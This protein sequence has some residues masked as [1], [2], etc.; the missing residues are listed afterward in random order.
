M[1]LSELRN[2]VYKYV[3]EKV[4]STRAGTAQPISVSQRLPKAKSATNDSEID[5]TNIIRQDLVLT[6]TCRQVRTEYL[7]IYSSHTA[8]I[9]MCS[10]PVDIVNAVK[11]VM[12][13]LLSGTVTFRDRAAPVRVNVTSSLN[14]V[15]PD[16]DCRP[17]FCIGKRPTRNLAILRAFCNDTT[18]SARFVEQVHSVTVHTGLYADA[19]VVITIK[20]EHGEWWKR[21]GPKAA[22]WAANKEWKERK[23]EWLGRVGLSELEGMDGV[24]FRWCRH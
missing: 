10:N 16:P 6:Q 13:P 5:W 21:H 3:S 12:L 19:K 18:R 11:G 15:A 2:E 24:H 20:F 1:I 14:C 4:T 17:N 7:P 22:M 9:A 23:D 8:L